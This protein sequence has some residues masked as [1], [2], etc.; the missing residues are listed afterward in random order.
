MSASPPDDLPGGLLGLGQCDPGRTD[1]LAALPRLVR[2]V[3]EEWGLTHDGPA[4]HGTSA[5]VVPVRTP[6]GAPAVAKF[7]WP[8]D[9]MQHEHLALQAWRG[10]GA[11]RLYRADPHR[12]VLLLER[13]HAEESLTAVETLEA[14][15]VVAGLYRRIHIPALPQLRTLSS[16]VTRWTDDLRSL[17]ADAPVPRR[18]VEQAVSLADELSSDE[19]SAGTMIHGDLHYGN[20]LAA[21]RQPW[22]VIDPKPVSGDPHYEVAP[23]LWNRWEEIVAAG[24]VRDAVRRRFHTLVDS[25]ELEE[26]RARNWV[27]V[28]EMHNALWTIREAEGRRGRPL[29]AEQTDEITRCI[30]IAKAVQD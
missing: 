9:E 3:V 17:P 10:D 27:I 30:S 7:G 20:V 29:S 11:V 13:A 15:A 16:Y 5:L 18:L 28:R 26:D 25:A 21:D 22:L 4:M 23:L 1:W 14:C 24:N 19:S 8:H 6:G 12:H 2:T